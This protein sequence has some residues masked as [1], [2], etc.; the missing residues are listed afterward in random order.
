MLRKLLLQNC[1][2]NIFSV[3]D[4]LFLILAGKRLKGI[5]CVRFTYTQTRQIL[6]THVCWD[7]LWPKNQTTWSTFRFN[8]NV[9][10]YG[11]QIYISI[12][13][14]QTQRASLYSSSSIS[15]RVDLKPSLWTVK[16]KRRRVLA[17]PGLQTIR[18]GT[19]LIVSTILQSSDF[20][21]SRIYL[22]GSSRWHVFQS[23]SSFRLPSTTFYARPNLR[24]F[25]RVD[26]KL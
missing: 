26:C 18:F 11:H 22:G 3:G 6:W 7:A 17:L 23:C 2:E 12:T 24:V 13:N 21:L 14:A 20:W 16:G 10:K 4:L 5:S 25:A 19:I 9:F 15:S 1:Q 8:L